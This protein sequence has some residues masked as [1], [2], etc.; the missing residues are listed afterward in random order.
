[1]LGG[2]VCLL[3]SIAFATKLSLLRATSR[4]FYRDMKNEKLSP[5]AVAYQ[6]L[7]KYMH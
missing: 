7:H 1:M 3:A 5:E 2:I 6:S 4:S